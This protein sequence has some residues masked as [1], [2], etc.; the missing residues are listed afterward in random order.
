[1][2]RA[3]YWSTSALLWLIPMTPA[4]LLDDR[5]TK[6][7]STWDSSERYT[8]TWWSEFSEL[9]M[10]NGFCPVA[11]NRTAQPWRGCERIAADSVPMAV[12]DPK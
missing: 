6:D 11:A 10:A 9:S 4:C 7:I 8:S 5:E 1:M 3:R 2:R 12:H